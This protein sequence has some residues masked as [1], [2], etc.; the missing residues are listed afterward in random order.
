MR[1]KYSLLFALCAAI[2]A[3]C[4][5]GNAPPPVDPAIAAK[6]AAEAKANKE[7]ALYEQMRQ[8]GS[9]DLAV[10]L[11][12]EVLANFPGTAAAARV[13]QTI[14]ETRTKA[15]VI[16]NT[17]RLAQLWSYT[18]TAE[19][20]GTQYAAAIAS[21]QAPNQPNARLRL[22]LRQ[23]PKW[24]RS[25]YLLLD[26]ATFDCKGG[27]ATL[28]VSFD[29]GKP[30]RMKATVPPTGE[31]ALFIDDDKGF[32]AKMEKAKTVDVGVKLKGIGEF[33]AEFEVGGFVADKW[34]PARK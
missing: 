1:S 8:N 4:S 27:C 24:G 13:Q 30:Q 34:M 18:A 7:A 31:P 14:D 25:V 3:A 9:W 17:R 32:I 12:S 19:D 11:G 10:S 5:G 22:V 21:K 26:N 6:A 16:A 20:G 33:N 28:P 2:L 23:H 15:E 29:D